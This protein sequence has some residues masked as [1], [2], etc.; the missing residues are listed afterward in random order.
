MKRYYHQERGSATVTPAKRAVIDQANSIITEYQRQGFQLTLRQLYYQ[1]VARDLIPN[2]QKE[3]KRLGAIITDGRYAGLIDWNAIEDRT[4]SLRGLTHWGSPA[5][6]VRA[7]AE[8]FRYGLWLDQPYRVEV[9]IEKDALVGVIEGICQQWDVDYFSCRGYV[10]A[11]EMWSAGRRLGRYLNQDRK[12]IVLHLGDHDPSGVDMSGDIQRRLDDFTIGDLAH[13]HGEVLGG[14]RLKA[15]LG[16]VD[17]RR[18]A[19]TMDQVEEF[20]PPPNPAKLGDSRSQRYI[21]EYGDESWEL[22][23]LDPAT[24]ANL[25]DTEIRGIVDQGRFDAAV[26][27]QEQA[28]DRLREVADQF[29]IE[30]EMIEEE[31]G[32]EHDGEE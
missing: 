3:Y 8:Q 25:I 7:S 6:I 16:T 18:I 1:F 9:W 17:V 14:E 32:D 12:V 26:G 23:A 30:E 20:N 29:E 24:L 28:R 21:E 31:T 19:L 11:S 5:E 22:D 2:Q 13:S 15:G 27:R 4:R 10:S